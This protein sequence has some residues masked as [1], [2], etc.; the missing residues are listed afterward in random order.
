MKSSVF[1]P[2][3]QKNVNFFFCFVL[4]I[5]ISALETYYAFIVFETCFVVLLP[6]PVPV[7][8][9]T[10]AV[11]VPVGTGETK[12]HSS[13]SLYSTGNDTGN[14]ILVNEVAGKVTCA[15]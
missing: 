6:L 14:M 8:A 4:I 15:V 7:A 12:S 2:V 9:I 11:L 10:A 5:K 13:S 1:R 3:S